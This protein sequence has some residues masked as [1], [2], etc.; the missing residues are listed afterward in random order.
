MKKF[1]MVFLMVISVMTVF[2]QQ[3]QQAPQTKQEPLPNTQ[4]MEKEG[5]PVWLAYLEFT[6]PYENMGKAIPQFMKEFMGQGLKPQGMLYCLYFNVPGPKIK[7]EELKW[8]YAFPVEKDA[9]VKEPLK[10]YEI[11][12]KMI[13]YSIHNG[14]YSGL[15]ETMTNTF[16]IFNSKNYKVI[17][18]V[19]NIFY[20]SPGEVKPEELKTEI[21]LPFDK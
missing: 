4:V 14:P 2:G 12:T 17:W 13:F 7:P 3:A 1:F 15:A 21:G 18:P 16:K 10:K 6:G 11:N 5:T 9:V 8:A 20:N 19:Y